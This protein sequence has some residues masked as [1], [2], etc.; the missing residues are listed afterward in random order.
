MIK[1]LFNNQSH[2]KNIYNLAKSAAIFMENKRSIIF[3]YE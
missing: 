2:R 3:T 1:T